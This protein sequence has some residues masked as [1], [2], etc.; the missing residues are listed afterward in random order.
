MT[1]PSTLTNNHPASDPTCGLKQPAT[2]R[3]KSETPQ[4]ARED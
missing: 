2:C 3:A 1:R 4:W